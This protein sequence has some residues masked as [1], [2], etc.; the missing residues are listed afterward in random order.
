VSCRPCAVKRQLQDAAYCL[1][2][3]W[4]GAW[5]LIITPA[6][7]LRNVSGVIGGPNPLVPSPLLERFVRQNLAHGRGLRPTIS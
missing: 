7:L 6:Q 2:L 5:G 4:W 1:C 3:G